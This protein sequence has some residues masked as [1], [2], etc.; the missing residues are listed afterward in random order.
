VLQW[1]LGTQQLSISAEKKAPPSVFLAV[2]WDLKY[3]TLQLLAVMV[4][5]Y[6]EGNSMGLARMETGRVWQFFILSGLVVLGMMSCLGHNSHNKLLG[7]GCWCM[8]LIYDEN[9]SKQT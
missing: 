8:V 5:I 6:L 3:R 4:T 1:Q 2:L 7:Y 9:C